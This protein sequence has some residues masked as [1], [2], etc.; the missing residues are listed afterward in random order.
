NCIKI[1]CGGVFG[2]VFVCGLCELV[3]A[4]FAFVALSV[5]IKACL[6]TV[7]ACALGTFITIADTKS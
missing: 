7:R 1:Q 2:D 5:V 4:V 3:S 6:Y